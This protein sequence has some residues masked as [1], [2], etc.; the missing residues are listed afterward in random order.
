[1]ASIKKV[2]YGRHYVTYEDAGLQK[3]YFATATA[4]KTFAKEAPGAVVDQEQG[5]GPVRWEVWYRDNEN[6]GRSRR[7]ARKAD[8]KKFAITVEAERQ[9]G[10]LLSVRA[11]EVLFRD[12]AETWLASRSLA[13]NSRKRKAGN[14]FNHAAPHIGHLRLKDITPEHLLT[15]LNNLSHLAETT[16]LGVYTD[17]RAT[18]AYAY[19]NRRIQVD[20]FT[21]QSVRS[22]KPRPRRRKVEPWTT[23]RV[24]RVHSA[25]PERYR[26]AVV[27]G[28]MLGLRQGE[29][30][31][32]S[33]DDL[34]FERCLVSVRRQ[35]LL[36]D[37]GLSFGPPKGGKE[38]EVPLSRAAGRYLETYLRKFPPATVSLPW[39]DPRGRSGTRDGHLVSTRLIL[40]TRER[41]ALNKNTFNRNT[42]RPALSVA[43]VTDMRRENG[44]H[45]LRHHFASV[46]LAAGESLKALSEYLGHHSSAYTLDTY[47]HLMP[48]SHA[49]SAAAIDAA[50]S[51][52]FHSSST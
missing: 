4:A 12:Y 37:S 27:L 47:T 46:L 21:L 23:E 25:L 11:G 3:R 26:V 35:V 48:D 24:Y 13:A 36:L 31:G 38:R 20:P 40:T 22:A 19:D 28:A 51:D 39:S 6:R 14:L 9:N 29:V 17:V 45:A 49:R 50:F 8:A 44:T 5:D 41:N 34:D 52:T 2:K 30:F 43:G 42:W 32:L 15:M 33:V 1:M 16:R 18:F 7:F 10:T